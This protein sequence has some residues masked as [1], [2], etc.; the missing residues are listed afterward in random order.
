MLGNI[1]GI[2]E[3]LVLIKLAI[4]INKFESLINIHV[5]MDDGKRQIIGEITDIKDNI[6]YVNLLGEMVDGRFV[7]GVIVKPSFSSVV[8]LI[9]KEKVKLVIT[10]DTGITACDEVSYANELS[11][12]FVITDH[13]ECRQVLPDAVAVVNPHRP[14]C[15]SAF[16]ELAGVGVVFKVI[17]A[18]EQVLNFK[19]AKDAAAGAVLVSSF[20][21]ALVG[22]IIF[23]P[24]I[25]E[26][27]GGK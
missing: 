15:P 13:H 14:D 4:D 25:M 6:A 19:T 8:K 11:V 2:E 16:K 20:V 18:L 26:L 3:N 21:A 17:C 27:L 12:D 9:S 24:K 7:F 10:V 22:I 5:I 23:L 1:I